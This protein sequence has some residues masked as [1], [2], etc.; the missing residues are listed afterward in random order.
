MGPVGFRVWWSLRVL[1]LL[2]VTSAG[3]VCRSTLHRPPE[4]KRSIAKLAAHDGGSL[5]DG[6]GCF[7]G[8]DKLRWDGF[9]FRLSQ[10]LPQLERVASELANNWPEE[11]G[12]LPVVGAYSIHPK[13]PVKLSI[14]RA[15]NR[16]PF[17]ETVGTFVS[18]TPTGH[19]W[20]GVA[21]DDEYILEFCPPG[22]SPKTFTY[23][24]AYDIVEYAPV[25][26]IPVADSVFLT[27]YAESSV[28]S[29]RCRRCGE[30]H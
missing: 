7:V 1:T 15:P 10:R 12:V 4:T 21:T 25:R 11:D 6:S 3:C 16:H 8:Y 29:P 14:R 22:E 18:K 13:L 2:A 24:Y 9:L 19:I 27:K 28:P 5:L 17:Y 26:S 20:F 30:I 23:E